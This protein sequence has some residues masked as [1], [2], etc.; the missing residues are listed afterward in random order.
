M[1]MVLYYEDIMDIVGFCF[2]FVV[3][4]FNCLGK[5]RGLFYVY[6]VE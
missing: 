4:G 6:V 5:M 1:V 2:V 3:C